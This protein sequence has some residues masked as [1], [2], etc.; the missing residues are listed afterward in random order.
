M[1]KLSIFLCAV[2]AIAAISCNKE[3]QEIPENPEPQ[4]PQVELFPMTFTATTADTRTVLD[5]DQEHILWAA[6]E[7]ISVFDGAGNQEFTSGGAGRKVTFSG[8]A[9]SANVYYALYP[10]DGSVQ[11][12]GTSVTTELASAQ[13]PCRGSFADGLNINAAQS[14]DK[15]TFVFDNVLSVAK[16]TLDATKLGGKTIK[17]VKLASKSDPLAGDVVINFGETC[18]AGPSTAEDAETF[19]EVSMTDA[20]GLADGTY[21]FVVLPNAGGEITM[22]FT[23]TDNSTATITANVAAF[24]AGRIKNLGTVKGLTW[25]APVW[26]LVTDASTL[27]VGDKLVIASN[28]KGK[29]ASVLSSSYLTAVDASFSSDK[30]EITLP[31]GAMQFELGGS[32]GSWTLT[33]TAGQLKSKSVKNVNFNEGTGTWDISIRDG[34]ATIQNTHATDDYG[35][36]LY[37]SGSPRFTTYT[38][39]VTSSMLLPQLYRE[40]PAS[41]VVPV[42]KE[43]NPN[44]TISEDIKK[45]FYV[46]DAFSFGQ[47]TVTASYSNGEPK[48]LAVG[49]VNVTG[50]NSESSTAA[51]AITLTYSENGKTATVSYSIQILDNTTGGKYKKVSSITP[52]KK[53]LIV[54]GNGD[55]YV[56]PHPVSSKVQD[57]VEV[58]IANGEIAADEDTDA[59]AFTISR[60]TVNNVSYYVITYD[61]NGN[62]Y[63][64][65]GASNSSTSIYSTTTVP[66]GTSSCA[67][68]NI[69]STSSFGSFYIQDA[70]ATKRGIHWRPLEKES[71]VNKFGHYS[72]EGGTYIYTNVHLYEFTSATN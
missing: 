43:L 35:R 21:Y 42:V 8:N 57:G 55:P 11:L 45:V 30:D 71:T 28:A 60:M 50:F 63:Y 52:G 23:A 46:G 41:G 31:D 61:N 6:G 26:K 65:M 14:T 4:T 2:T 59:C 64:V 48:T 24:G 5:D 51:Q 22:T 7:K 9:A 29:V 67:L 38:S 54:A 70:G 15:E 36:F 44:L 16:F 69:S 47:G 53:Y 10:Y 3:I 58:N 56:L 25:A 1:K 49:E 13:T 19:K 37:N 40:E 66:G 72:A 18:T 34:D 33:S 62:T 12:S 68:W 39:D 27:A 32:V 17:S 20:N